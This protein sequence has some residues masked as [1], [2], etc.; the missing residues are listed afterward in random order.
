[1]PANKVQF[2]SQE[3]EEEEE[4]AEASNDIKGA[5]SKNYVESVDKT[6]GQK[7]CQKNELTE[8]YIS[9]KI[10]YENKTASDLR[11]CQ[12]QE[13]L[14][15]RKSIANIENDFQKWGNISEKL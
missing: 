3:E 7:K 12:I 11:K 1:M 2:H 15:S 4:G 9:N 5:C 6:A 10:A 14:N 13:L 8:L